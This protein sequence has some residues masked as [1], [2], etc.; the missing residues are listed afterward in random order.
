VKFFL[1]GVADYPGAT[2]EILS[3]FL[4]VSLFAAETC[5]DS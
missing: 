5:A 3:R 2:D 4:K 1:G